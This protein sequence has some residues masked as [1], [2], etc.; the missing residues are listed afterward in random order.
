MWQKNHG[1]DKSFT[2][3]C[4]LPIEYDLEMARFFAVTLKQVNY[5]HICYCRKYA[6][7]QF[8]ADKRLLFLPVFLRFRCRKH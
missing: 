7:G 5:C 2:N 6:R 1:E 3:L 4:V 8:P